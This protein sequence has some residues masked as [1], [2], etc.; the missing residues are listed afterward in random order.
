MTGWADAHRLAMVAAARVLRRYN[1]S[2]ESQVPLLRIVEGEGVLARFAPLPKMAGAYF[3]E[4]DHGQNGML[5]NTRLPWSKQRYTIGHELGHHVFG[6]GSRSDAGTDW[7]SI[8]SPSTTPDDELVAEAFAAWLLMPKTT[9]SQAVRQLGGWTPGLPIDAYRLS[10]LLGTS[11]RATCIHLAQ[12]KFLGWPAVR[13]MLK[14]QPK[15]IKQALLGARTANVGPADVHVVRASGCNQ[16]HVRSGDALIFADGLP[17]LENLPTYMTLCNG[18]DLS[19]AWLSVG[20]LPVANPA[21]PTST[22]M[23]DTASGILEVV[24]HHRLDGISE[25]WFQ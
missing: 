8:D 3:S 12:L 7:I 1:V 25:T 11:Y 19:S 6:H 4:A 14:V 10:L 23:V 5:I 15:E 2:P 9:V 18:D 13:K 17:V 20:S 21:R 16:V 22:A 24:A